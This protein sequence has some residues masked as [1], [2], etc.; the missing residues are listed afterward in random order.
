MVGSRITCCGSTNKE[1][2]ILD[3]LTD[4]GFVLRQPDVLPVSDE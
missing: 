3:I 2:G 4:A 1:E